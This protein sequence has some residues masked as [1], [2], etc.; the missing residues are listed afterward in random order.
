[1]VYL[2]YSKIKNYLM[3]DKF[4]LFISFPLLILNP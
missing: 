4:I 2:N 1:M 3:N